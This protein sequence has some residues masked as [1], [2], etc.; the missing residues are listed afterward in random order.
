MG[1]GSSDIILLSNLVLNRFCKILKINVR[2]D[3]YS[4]NWLWLSWG[5]SRGLYLLDNGLFSRKRKSALS[6][7]V[8]I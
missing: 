4:S 8:R 5:L 6:C 3:R 7:E 2:S 1:K